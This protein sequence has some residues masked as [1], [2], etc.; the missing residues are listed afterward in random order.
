MLSSPLITRLLLWIPAAAYAALVWWLS[1]RSSVSLPASIS[2]KVAHGLAFAGLATLV[3]VAVNG[4]LL[5][6]PAIGGAVLVIGLCAGYA[7]VDEVHQSFVPGRVASVGDVMADT[8]GALLVVAALWIAG[9]RAAQ[10]GDE[11]RG[12]LLTLLSKDDCHLCLEAE[13][14]LNRVRGEIPFRLE[15]VNVNSDEEL[16]RDYGS[17]VPVVLIDG[18]K[19]FKYRV[20]PDKLRRRLRGPG[21]KVES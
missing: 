12:P 6:R 2:D 8:A 18:K 10:S 17:E 21:E 14:V 11:A 13:E 7:A 15:K 4:R 19:V 5:R 9:S 20:D 1:S 16:A 3:W